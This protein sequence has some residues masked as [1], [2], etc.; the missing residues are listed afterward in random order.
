[1]RRGEVSCVWNTTAP[2]GRSIVLDLVALPVRLQSGDGRSALTEAER[3]LATIDAGHLATASLDELSDGE[4]QLVAVA[5]ALVTKPRV[6]LLDQPAVNLH[7][8]EEK[9]L[10]NVLGALAHDADVAV[11]MTARNAG[12]AIA[13]DTVA[14]LSNGRLFVG[15]TIT[16]REGGGAEVLPIDGRR[17]DADKGRQGA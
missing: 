17:N 10:L 14:S 7:L 11:L 16:D 9:K 4:R 6:L 8:V 12:E 15:E 1:M 13:A 5:Q 2:I 3:S